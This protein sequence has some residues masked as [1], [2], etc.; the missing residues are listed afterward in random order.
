MKRRTKPINLPLG[1]IISGTTR[2][3]DRLPAL[4]DAADSV[5]LTRTERAIITSVKR[6]WGKLEGDDELVDLDEMLQDVFNVME[7]HVPD[8][9]RLGNCEGDGADLGVWVDWDAIEHAD[10]IHRSPNPPSI[11]YSNKLMDPPDY[12]LYINDHGN[13]TLYRRAGT[14]FIECWSL[15]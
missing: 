1:S 11:S 15:V 4:L 5:H 2:A 8:Y 3:A 13:E 7:S 12:W 14:R 9:C 6:A 10:D